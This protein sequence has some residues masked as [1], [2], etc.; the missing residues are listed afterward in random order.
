MGFISVQSFS[1]EYINSM[2]SS[3]Y[4]VVAETNYF[5][6]SGVFL[7]VLVGLPNILNMCLI[8]VLLMRHNIMSLTA[9]TP[10]SSNAKRI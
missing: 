10:I 9:N 6:A 5:D 4:H 8:L 7:G 1:L 3:H 2:M